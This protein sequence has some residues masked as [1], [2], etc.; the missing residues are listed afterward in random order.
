M[1]WNYSHITCSLSRRNIS[2]YYNALTHVDPKPHVRGLLNRGV[3]RI[4]NCCVPGLLE[5]REQIWSSFKK[6]LRMNV[7]IP[8]HEDW[9]RC[10]S[11]SVKQRLFVFC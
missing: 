6:S 10:Y 1:C 8:N 9:K 3:N 4:F 2:H 7:T 11:S 5:N